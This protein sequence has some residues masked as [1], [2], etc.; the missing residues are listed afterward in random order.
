LPASLD[1]Y[2]HSAY[3]DNNFNMV[4]PHQDSVH[5]CSFVVAVV[6]SEETESWGA[7][8]VAAESEIS[9]LQLVAF[10]ADQNER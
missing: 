5:Y 3:A 8:F 2:W 6:Q 7:E 1:T 9:A 4:P 10:A